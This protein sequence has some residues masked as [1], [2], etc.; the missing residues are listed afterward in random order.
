MD[1]TRTRAS[2]KT[3]HWLIFLL[4]FAVFLGAVEST[5]CHF[6]KK[7]YF[8]HKLREMLVYF[9]LSQRRV[10]PRDYSPW[11]DTDLLVRDKQ[12]YEG[13]K[14]EPYYYFDKL[15]DKAQLSAMRALLISPKTLKKETRKRIFITGESAAFGYPFPYR[16]TFAALLE[17]MLGTDKYTV[18]NAA[19]PALRTEQAIA[20]AR[21]I[22]DLYEPDIL[23]VYA[24]NNLWL[25]WAQELGRPWKYTYFINT[26]KILSQSRALS[27]VLYYSIRSLTVRR[28]NRAI[29]STAP[30]D[31]PDYLLERA[32][33]D[34]TGQFRAFWTTSRDSKL[35]DFE[36]ELTE[37]AEYARANK[38]RLILLTV[39]F[40]YKLPPEIMR[41]QPLAYDERS[42][43]HAYACADLLKKNDNSAALEAVNKALGYDGASAVLCYLK[44][45]CYEKLGRPELAEKAYELY[46]ENTAGNLGAVLSV[47]NAIRQAAEATGCEFI[48]IKILFDAGEHALGSYFNERLICDNCHPSVEGHAIIARELYKRIADTEN[49][50]PR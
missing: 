11:K 49:C 13:L 9:E 40:A 22:I 39:P 23:I 17:E 35:A 15:V 4:C 28:L 20:E 46:R 16:H 10:E 8:Q 48:D 32:I 14:A 36:K 45:Y 42:F 29:P 38:V 27:A 7:Y 21:R 24:G 2:L 30:A 25:T 37:L 33:K 44:G 31:T 50:A 6:D 26:A 43:R 5:A 41:S 18:I 47:N 3:K 34:N 12:D 19:R 1:N